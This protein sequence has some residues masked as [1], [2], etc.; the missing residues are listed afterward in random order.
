MAAKRILLHLSYV[1][2]DSLLQLAEEASLDTFE[3]AS[4]DKRVQTIRVKA[5]ERALQKLRDAL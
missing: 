5:A 4:S 1:E 3:S 2:A